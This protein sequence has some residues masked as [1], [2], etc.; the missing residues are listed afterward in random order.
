MAT[1][2]TYDG[3]REDERVACEVQPLA[4]RVHL[5]VCAIRRGRLRPGQVL[6]HELVHLVE[7]RH[8]V[9]ATLERLHSTLSRENPD[10]TVCTVLLACTISLLPLPKSP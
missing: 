7:R 9:E 10:S 8:R 4:N 1:A 2:K 6:P 3:E 5:L